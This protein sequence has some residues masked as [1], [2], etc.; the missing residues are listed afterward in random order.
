VRA[1]PSFVF[2]TC[3]PDA[4]AWLRDEIARDEPSLRMSWSRPGVV[5]YRADEEAARDPAA[6]LAAVFA[7]TTG[8]S[9]GIAKSLEEVVQRLADV[10]G[11]T[12]RVHVYA[13]DPKDEERW[14]ESDPR[15]A[16]WRAELL[17][18][19]APR[20][21]DEA[22]ASE[23][24]VV[25]DVV[26]PPLDLPADPVLV[27]WHVQRSPRSPEPGG[28]ARVPVPDDAPS[29]AYA[30]LEEALAWSGAPVQRGDVAV[31]IGSAPGGAAFALLRRGLEVIAIDPARLDE[32]VTAYA[33]GGQLR[34]LRV[35]AERVRGRDL[36][37]RV[38]WLLLD[39]NVAPHRALV[40]VEHLLA[41]RRDSLRGLLLTLKLNDE[42]VV[43]DLPDLLSRIAKLTGRTQS[44]D[45][46][47]HLR[48]TQ[49]P[50][51]HRE[52][53]VWVSLR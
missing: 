38:D 36:P 5:T 9:L 49:V 17:G 13:R 35:L 32:R 8:I 3:R 28:V 41:T 6:P 26:L 24:D 29:R 33:D 18:R 43:R 30:K 25:A 53:V 20:A 2:A 16:E 47:P 51:A 34:H 21:L 12:I 19:L 31:E 37:D 40:A 44:S 45:R 4:T 42:G 46:E 14:H 22:R 15:P 50:S 52:V 27:G 11:E 48:A 1:V 10:P 39:A 7:R 23:G